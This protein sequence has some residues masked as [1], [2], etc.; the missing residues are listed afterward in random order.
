MNTTTYLVKDF[1][2]SEMGTFDSIE[3]ARAKIERIFD[4]D[5]MKD[6]DP[7]ARFAVES[8]TDGSNGTCE[9]IDLSKAAE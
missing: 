9:I 5:E 6:A 4:G 8:Y 3:A 7:R 2:G 1:S